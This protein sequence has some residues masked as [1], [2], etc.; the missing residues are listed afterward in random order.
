MYTA[1]QCCE[2]DTTRGWVACVKVMDTIITC[3]LS[4]FFVL[5]LF[6]LMK[7]IRILSALMINSWS[8]RITWYLDPM[9]LF[10][11]FSY[12]VGVCALACDMAVM[13]KTFSKHVSSTYD[14]S[15]LKTCYIDLSHDLSMSLLSSNLFSFWFCGMFFLTRLHPCEEPMMQ[16]AWGSCLQDEP[17]WRRCIH[18]TSTGKSEVLDDHIELFLRFSSW[19]LFF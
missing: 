6:W 2:C 13:I 14:N 17:T 18:M 15:W 12:L 9:F 10:F 8:T 5:N 4:L 3:V 11:I 16:M 19:P 7:A 1:V